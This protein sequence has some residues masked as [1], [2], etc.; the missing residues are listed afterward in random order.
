VTGTGL[1]LS[2]ES[3]R[4]FVL[5]SG[6]RAGTRYPLA[7]RTRI[8]RSPENDIVVEGPASATVSLR[9]AEIICEGA[10]CH[11]IDLKST[12]GAFVNGSPITDAP[13]TAP[14]TIRL[15]T[16]GPEFVLVFEEISQE[17]GPE[18][19]SKTI[20]VPRSSLAL[21]ASE[22]WP[23]GESTFDGLRFLTTARAD[24]SAGVI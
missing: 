14:A 19:L 9:H 17:T 4:R 11:I 6:A 24:E 10:A 15:G 2:A 1:G 23:P 5:V 8:G 22:T 18:Q 16:L 13:L 20:F 21:P 7:H 12:N 3:G